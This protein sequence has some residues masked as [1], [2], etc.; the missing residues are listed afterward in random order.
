M[1]NKAMKRR[2]V[3]FQNQKNESECSASDEI[4]VLWSEYMIDI[5]GIP[6]S[7]AEQRIEAEVDGTFHYG[8]LQGLKSLGWELS[9]AVVLDIGC[10]TGALASALSDFGASLI[11]IEPSLPWVKTARRRFEEKHRDN[12]L[13]LQGDGAN[14]SLLENSIDYVI[15]LQVLEHVPMESAK[16]IIREIAR[17]LKPGGRVY[18]SFENYLSFW[19]PHYRV[20]WFPYLPKSIGKLYL[21]L[22][23]RDPGFLLNHVYYNSAIGIAQACLESGL[24]AAGWVAY[25][26]K[27][28]NT[29]LIESKVKR[30]GIKVLQLIPEGFQ[31]KIIV[32]YSERKQLFK[33]GFTLELTNG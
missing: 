18:L 29:N 5:L 19:E 10:G 32:I 28:S 8:L 21:K 20:R 17:V 4:R 6:Q 13:F 11:G 9:G 22:L 2:W 27:L 16:E 14:N 12:Y 24:M 1:N 33:T 15:S 31:Q 7:D 25:S 3:N 30:L 23:G 26:E